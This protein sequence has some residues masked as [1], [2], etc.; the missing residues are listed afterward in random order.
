MRNALIYRTSTLEMGSFL[1]NLERTAWNCG[2]AF[3]TQ[4][5]PAGCV[6]DNQLLLR[7]F[8]TST[9]FVVTMNV[10]A[11]AQEPGVGAKWWV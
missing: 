9:Q 6:A 4:T 8:C 2:I 10:L 7:V 11:V 3:E 5:C 1:A